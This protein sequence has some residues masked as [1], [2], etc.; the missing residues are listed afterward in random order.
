MR[1]V[2][3]AASTLLIAVPRGAA[4][5]PIVRVRA[6]TRIE[7]RVQRTEHG[8]I[9]QGTLRDDRGD[10][11]PDRA[12]SL[13]VRGADGRRVVAR[14]EGRTDEA[15][16]VEASF[17]LERGEYRIEADYDGEDRYRGVRVEQTLDLERE[18]VRLGMS[19]DGEGRLDRLDLD[20]PSHAFR[21]RADSPL[22]G[23]GLEVVL[24]NELRQELAQGTT[25]AE[26]VARFVVS[27]DALGPPA[28]GRL[29][30]RT[31]G[32]ARRAAAQ[33]EVLVVRF[34]STTLTLAGEPEHVTAGG[35]V[36]VEGRLATSAGPLPRKAIGIFA[37]E[38]HLAT[39][40]TDDEGRFSRELE[41]RAD[42]GPV[43]LQARFASD[44]PWRPAAQSEPLRIRVEASGAT[45]WQWLLV[46]VAVCFLLVVLLSRRDRGKATT[47]PAEEQ[48]AP[49]EPGIVAAR[50]TSRVA[51]VTTIGGVVFDADDRRA[52]GGARVRL[53]SDGG[54]RDAE[55]DSRGEFEIEGIDHGAW[56]LRIEAPGYETS[57]TSLAV[58]H[59]GQW[60][61]VRVG[62]R[63]LRQLALARYRPL[64]E[65]LAP[66]RR[67][68]A[69]WTPRELADRASAAVRD[70]VVDVTDDVERAAYAEA[71]PRSEDVDAIGDRA[72]RL[73]ERI[74]PGS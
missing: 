40:L 14:A 30:V 5:Q 4:A 3:L 63:S 19:L 13:R 55:T 9:L 70:D 41:L 47:S 61:D 33:T 28:A 11:L 21:V 29:V 6:E 31:A 38:E 20:Q 48:E 26:G 37:G 58:P 22:G 15:G 42:E 64:A 50:A 74:E 44:A 8:A 73:A 25:N 69:F 51:T 32:D 54:A 53:Q 67:W 68:W 65:A 72:G 34:R 71:P 39:V 57:E 66:S 56:T 7:L 24:R 18:H 52:I 10:P 49:P 46:S 2:L 45:P 36:R 23:S 12:V 16:R 43:D 35:S 27:S 62:L 1:W 17:E 59:R 60:S